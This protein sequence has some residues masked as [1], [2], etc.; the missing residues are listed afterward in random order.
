VAENYFQR[1]EH[2][3]RSMSETEV[4]EAGLRVLRVYYHANQV[5]LM[6]R[7][8]RGVQVARQPASMAHALRPNGYSDPR[9]PHAFNHIS[10][11]EVW[12]HRAQAIE[13]GGVIRPSPARS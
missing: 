1:A 12:R 7:T 9:E 2:Y 3:F 5:I 13:R 10:L 11:A 4:K 8:D 6:R